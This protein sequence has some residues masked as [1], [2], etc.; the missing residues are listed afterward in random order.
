MTVNQNAIKDRCHL[1]LLTRSELVGPTLYLGTRRTLPLINGVIDLGESEGP[2]FT[3]DSTG[4]PQEVVYYS[5]ENPKRKYGI[6]ILHPQHKSGEQPE[7]I[8]DRIGF[9]V[10][11]GETDI[12]HE[13]NQEEIAEEDRVAAVG[14]R[15]NIDTDA[16]AEPE[17]LRTHSFK[18]SSMGISFCVHLPVGSGIEIFFPQTNKFQWQ[19]SSGDPLPVNG[20]YF[21]V[22][23]RKQ[24]KKNDD[25]LEINGHRRVPA[26]APGAVIG[27]S[28]SDLQSDSYRKQPVPVA[29]GIYLLMRISYRARRI[30]GSEKWLVTV[31]LINETEAR[32]GNTMNASLFQSFFNVKCVD[33]AS[34]EPY[35]EPPQIVDDDEKRSLELLYRNSKTWGIGHNCAAGWITSGDCIN[36]VFADV[37]PVI[38][39][40]SM[41]PDILAKDKTELKFSMIELSELDANGS[42]DTWNKLYQIRDEYRDWLSERRT[43]AAK[44]ETQYQS[45]ALKHLDVCQS[46]LGRIERGI[47]TLRND[48]N[49]CHAFRLANRSMVMQQLATKQLKHRRLVFNS[50][51]ARIQ[52]EGPYR[53]PYQLITNGNVEKDF[54]NWRA[55][56]LAFLLMNVPEFVNESDS[57]DFQRQREQV[58]LIWFPT[59]GGKTEAY[60][61]VAAYS[62]FLQRI[63]QK[64]QPDELP[65]DGTNVIMRYTLRMLTTQQFQRAAALICSM[66]CLRQLDAGKTL[67]GNQFS[68]GL[69][70][71]G[72]GSPNHNQKALD[73]ISRYR[74]EHS[75]QKTNPLILTECP[76]CRAQLGRAEKVS[77]PKGWRDDD[78]K[79]EKVKGIKEV[80]GKPI[81]CCSDINC[82]FHDELPV[83]VIDEQ[84][85]ESPAS[86]VIG[87]AD[88]FAVLAYRPDARSLFGRD[89][90]GG[91]A[92]RPPNM[93]IQDE[94]HLIAGPLGTMFGLY[95]SVIGELC[96]FRDGTLEVKPKIICS[97]A[98]IRGAREQLQ[99]VFARDQ[100]TLFPAPGIDISDS[101]FGRYATETDGTL[102][103][104][105]MYVGVNAPDYI[106]SQTTQVRVFSSLL[107]N[108]R[109]QIEEAR[110]DPWW[111]NLIFYNSLRELGGSTTLFQGDIKSRMKFLKWRDGVEFRSDP[112]HVELSSRLK[113]DEIIAMLD[114]LAIN[115]PTRRGEERP[116]DACLASNIIEVG[117]DID[118]LSL[119][120]V[121]GQPKSTAQYIQ[122]TGR[123][124]RR[125]KDRPGLVFT[126][127][128]PTKIRDK[129]H[130]EQFYSYHGR[131]YEQVEPTSATPFSRASL[132]RGVIGA[133]LVYARLTLPKTNAPRYAD[134]QSG[135]ELAKRLLIERAR[136]VDPVQAQEAE[137]V[138]SS[139]ADRLQRRWNHGRDHW[140]KIP[141]GPDDSVLLRW[142]GQFV[143]I[144]RRNESF[145]VPS[146]LRQVD[147]SGELVITTFYLDQR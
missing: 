25:P 41:T 92:K 80:D 4:V 134:Y 104:G 29:E 142:P 48:V 82:S 145:E 107:V 55:F 14:D 115:Y 10:A 124:G 78:W 73:L 128:S 18:S 116:L 23:L 79:R 20:C 86:L 37:F 138:I 146:S 65:R 75:S 11:P 27:I 100:F 5:R 58:E 94:L 136:T 16:G 129:S 44:L 122:V 19:I 132:E 131:L 32:L 87:T 8:D 113:Q 22:V 35:P 105:R 3:N 140:E 61:G 47:D 112:Y 103:P 119:M 110:R 99:A 97:T 83:V 51:A 123:V 143:K 74:R 91:V 45:A 24:I 118:R 89:E 2:V 76:W 60:L 54:G 70:I 17:A 68:L 135:L 109:N 127:Y 121:V 106:S 6:G 46:V 21:P 117:V 130:Y 59:G 62:M 66:E 114:T 34:F 120:C 125:P 88:K 12:E 43:D 72:D 40:A 77:K 1:L 30:E 63:Y 147:G 13:P 7:G 126:L 52:P 108:V 81:L 50:F 67:A 31:T 101:F 93:V 90:Y 64:Q 9:T 56:Q 33:G 141:L 144:A 137:I 57:K 53:T 39:T 38:E 36:E 85:Y 15:E 26:F 95:E 42:M 111:T 139:I 133:M 49:A 28:A 98:T 71:G 84:L 102:M 69:W 96:T